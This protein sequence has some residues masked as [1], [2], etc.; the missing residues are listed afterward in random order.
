MASKPKTFTAE[1][2]IPTKFATAKDKAKFANHFVRF[3]Q[4]D[5]NHNLFYRWFYVRLSMCFAHIAHYN[6]SGF[7]IEWFSTKERQERFL[8]RC[9]TFPCYGQPG[10]TYS[11]VEKVLITW[12]KERI[13][14]L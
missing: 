9:I 1:Q 8:N 13:F 2:F 5:F 7:Y 6:K 14:L 3:V 10:S 4:S 12:M 11:D